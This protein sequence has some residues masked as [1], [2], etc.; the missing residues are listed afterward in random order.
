MQFLQSLTYAHGVIG[1][2]SVERINFLIP[3]LAEINLTDLT[4]DINC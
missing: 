3:H 1:Q 2:L 4:K